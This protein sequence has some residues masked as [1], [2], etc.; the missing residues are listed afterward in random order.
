[1]FH[2][3]FS[4]DAKQHF[5]CDA[6][7]NFEYLPMKIVHCVMFS[8]QSFISQRWISEYCF[9]FNRG[10]NSICQNRSECIGRP[11][12]CHDVCLNFVKMHHQKIKIA[13]LYMLTGI[14]DCC[15]V[16]YGAKKVLNLHFSFFTYGHAIW[17]QFCWHKVVVGWFWTFSKKLNFL[18]LSLCVNLFKNSPSQGVEFSCFS[19]VPFKIQR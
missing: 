19:L 13:M 8:D 18:F 12:K 6:L 17:W 15:V 9:L 5:S 1:M 16:Y 11:H 10:T 14:S 2:S 4:I 3:L 7:H